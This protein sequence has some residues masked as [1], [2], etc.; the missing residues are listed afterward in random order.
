MIY[1][2]NRGRHDLTEDGTMWLIVPSGSCPS[3]QAERAWIEDSTSPLMEELARSVGLNGKLS[4]PTSWRRAWKRAPWIQRLCG[5]I[6]EPSTAARGVERWI[7]SLR[8]TRASHSAMRVAAADRTIRAT[9]GPRSTESFRRFVP[10]SSF[11]KTSQGM[12][13][14]GLEQ[15][16]EISEDQGTDL[17]RLS[18]ERRKWAHPTNGNGCSSWHTATAMDSE[19]AGSV[20]RGDGLLL[21][22]RQW[23][24]AAAR[25]GKSPNMMSYE[26]RGGGKKGEQ[27]PNFVNQWATPTEDDM[28][29][30]TA[31]RDYKSLAP[32][33]SRWKT[34]HGLSQHEEGGEF[35]KEA[36]KWPTATATNAPL[37]YDQSTFNG[38]YARKVDGRKHQTDLQISASHFSPPDQETSKNG[39]TSSPRGP[40]SPRQWTTPTTA[41]QEGS[42]AGTT[43]RGGGRSL[44]KDATNF[45]QTESKRLNP[46]FVFWLMGWDLDAIC[47]GSPATASS[48]YRQRMRSALCG[49]LS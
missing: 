15:S 1:S 23:P 39:R 12:L 45:P 44:R 9:C 43:E 25:D 10:P 17:R 3:A 6:S 5:R 4:P 2:V 46:I 41:D 35:A 40:T 7:A 34:P 30:V 32:D 8:D 48:H 37:A 28:S 31:S 33:V 21:M 38:K 16:L 42:T 36:E 18:S 13:G 14:L 20:A 47:F 49:L 24:T 19:D 29:N 22:A 26:E 27:L 11:W